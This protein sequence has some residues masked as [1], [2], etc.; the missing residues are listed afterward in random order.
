MVHNT[1][2]YLFSLSCTSVT[3]IC[4]S[5]KRTCTSDFTSL[6]EVH[7]NGHYNITVR[8]RSAYWEAYS[9]RCE[10]ELLKICK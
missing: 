1:F 5:T 7:L 3:E 9:D 4:R 8:A 2:I 10:I 6:N